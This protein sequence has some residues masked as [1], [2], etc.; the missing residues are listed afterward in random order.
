MFL[1]KYLNDTYLELIYSNYD[2]NYVNGIDKENFDEVYNYLKN[3]N[4]YFIDD[5]VLN[6]LELFT[7]GK[8]YIELAINDVKKI[9]GNDYINKIGH[10]MKVID[11][12]IRISNSYSEKDK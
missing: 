11:Y 8:K 7:I 12:I 5:I 3:N 10:D 2:L 4:F 1:N 6:Y 9:I